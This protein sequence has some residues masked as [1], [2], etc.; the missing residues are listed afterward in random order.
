MK[1]FESITL[2][3]LRIWDGAD[4]MHNTPTGFVT[5]D[6]DVAN[7]WKKNNVGADYTTTSGTLISSLDDLKEGQDH[8]DRRNALRR[9]SD[10]EKKLL[11]LT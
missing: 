8:L 10:H 7:E 9:L 2:Y 11:G 3:V 5:T 1:N 4:G 6:I